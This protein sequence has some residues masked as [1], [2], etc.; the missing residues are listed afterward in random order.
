M[1]LLIPPTFAALPPYLTDAEVGAMCEP[2][3]QPAAQCR[4][5]K[6]TLKL[7]IATKPNG[8]PLVLRTELERALGAG[9]IRQPANESTLTGPN[10]AAL[11]QHLTHRKN[12]AAR[13]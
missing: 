5:L 8:R 2:L 10:V 3:R 9:R 6:D 12:H 11:R 13:A 4:Y 1:Q 7:M